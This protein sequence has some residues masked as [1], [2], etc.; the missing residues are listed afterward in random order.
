MRK[1]HT[2]QLVDWA[3]QLRDEDEE[4]GAKLEQ[5][6]EVLEETQSELAL[7]R[8]AVMITPVPIAISDRHGSFTLWNHAAADVMRLPRPDIPVASWHLHF[9]IWKDF[10]CTEAMPYSELPLLR[11]LRSGHEETGAFW[12]TGGGHK[13]ARIVATGRPVFDDLGR[14]IAGVV[15]WSVDEDG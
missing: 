10:E 13:P 9:D 4:R 6:Q 12:I 14:L 11:A 7:L 2:E 3:R 5:A 1:K 15:T 8:A